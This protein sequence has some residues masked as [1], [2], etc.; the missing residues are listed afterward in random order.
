MWRCAVNLNNN[1]WVST[2]TI[3][4]PIHLRSLF[5]NDTHLIPQTKILKLGVR[6]PEIRTRARFCW[7]RLRSGLEVSP[8][9]GSNLEP[10]TRKNWKLNKWKSLQA[11]NL[12]LGSWNGETFR[13]FLW[14]S[15]KGTMAKLEKFSLETGQASKLCSHFC[16]VAEFKSFLKTSNWDRDRETE[17]ET[18]DRNKKQETRNKKNRNRSRQ[19]IQSRH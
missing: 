3:L 9:S 11:V 13:S 12:A 10:P 2:L 4:W 8:E 1:K 19:K 15:L 18:R 7:E 16:T 6:V 17:T 5:Y 14:P